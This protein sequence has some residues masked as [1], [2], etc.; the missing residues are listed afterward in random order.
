MSRRIGKWVGTVGLLLFL[1]S[2]TA[3]LDRGASREGGEITILDV[4]TPDL[5]PIEWGTLVAV[6]P[7]SGVAQ[8]NLWLQDE[9]GTIRVIGYNHAN[10]QLRA[11]GR[12]L[13][14]R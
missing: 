2:C 4:P 11:Q 1:T 3:L 14:R 10:N 8:S 13:R 7:V 5:V 12:L 6:T 9:S